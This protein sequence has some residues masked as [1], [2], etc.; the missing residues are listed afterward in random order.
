MKSFGIHILIVFFDTA[1]WPAH[2]TQTDL[3][4]S[5]Q[6]ICL[7]QNVPVRFTIPTASRV[8][9]LCCLLHIL[10]LIVFHDNSQLTFLLMHK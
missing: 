7:P 4:V 8:L 10:F 9:P 1:S 6:L 3:L 5:L 2:N